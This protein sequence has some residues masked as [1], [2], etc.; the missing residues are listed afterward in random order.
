VTRLLPRSIH[1]GVA[2]LSLARLGAAALLAAMPCAALALPTCDRLVES[3][4]HDCN[5]R[6][7][8]DTYE[9]TQQDVVQLTPQQLEQ[10]L[11]QR[12]MHELGLSPAQFGQV[13]DYCRGHGEIRRRIGIGQGVCADPPPE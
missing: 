13:Q 2:A 4:I 6:L 8:L 12:P 7:G 10:A 9:L 11:G 5:L 1:P 3:G